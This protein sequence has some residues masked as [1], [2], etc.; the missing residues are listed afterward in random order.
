MRL[1]NIALLGL[2]ALSASSS[3]RASTHEVVGWQSCLTETYPASGTM[4]RFHCTIEGSY[5]AKDC[6]TAF[7][8]LHSSENCCSPQQAINEYHGNSRCNGVHQ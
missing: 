1:K 6:A 4:H 5:E 2:L 3:G 8:Q 7:A